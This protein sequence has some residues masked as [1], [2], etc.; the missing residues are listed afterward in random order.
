MVKTQKVFARCIFD[1]MSLSP[2][3]NVVITGSAG[4]LG[5]RIVQRLKEFDYNVVQIDKFDSSDPVDL[6]NLNELRELRLPE[7]YC[8]VHLAF[9]LPGTFPRRDFTKT[10]RTINENIS[11]VFRPTKTLL[12]SSTAVYPLANMKSHETKPWEIY[13]ILKLETER[14]FQKVFQAVTIFRPGTLIEAN[15]N[16]MMMIFLKQL[17]RSRYPVIPFPKSIVHPFTHTDDLV[18]AIIGWVKETNSSEGIFDLVAGDPLTFEQLT[19]LD[20]KRVVNFLIQ[21]PQFFLR[22]IGSDRFPLFKISKWHFSAL[23]YN[24]AESAPHKF[25]KYSRTYR[26]IFN[27]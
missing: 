27:F 14:V 24:Y 20:D 23:T 6:G 22:R 3:V 25:S 19:N 15:R 7:Q 17:L 26:E 12:V 16:S 2:V 8:F 9:P 4:Y 10:I 5:S 21:I 18:E 1:T 11:I 13:G